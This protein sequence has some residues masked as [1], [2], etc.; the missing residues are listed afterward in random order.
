MTKPLRIFIDGHAFDREYQGTHSFLR[1]LYRGVH[2]LDPSVALFVGARDGERVLQALPFLPASRILPYR[3]HRF[4]SLRFLTD[5]PRWIRQHRFDFAHFQYLAPRRSAACRYIV[6][7]HDLL[8]RDQQQH[9]PAPYRWIRDPLF[10]SSI[11]RA[12]IRTTVSAY[13][14]ERIAHHYQLPAESLHVLPC[15]LDGRFGSGDLA[16]AAGER[17]F[18][19]YGI[20]NYLL[21]VS[22]I[23]PRKNQELLLRSYLDLRLYEEGLQLVFVGQPS[24]AHPEFQQLLNGLE[25]HLHP[26]VHH[27]EQVAQTDLEDLYQAA[28]VF[29]YPSRGEGFG[30]PPLEAALCCVPVLCSQATA[31]ADFDFFEPFRFHPED[32]GAFRR[33]LRTI[34]DQPPDA[35]GLEAIRAA[36]LQRYESGSVAKRFLHL[37]QTHRS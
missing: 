28:R 4:A 25:A 6:T 23:E 2:Q 15:S 20:R 33:Q 10:R 34:L 30:I 5:I 21:C 13:S 8:F 29:V 16:I 9:F 24:I 11:R 31:M 32:G 36:V 1:E 22:R 12:A 14:Q 37:L 27:L 18:R 35:G 26:M 17:I 19:Q 3:H 7:T